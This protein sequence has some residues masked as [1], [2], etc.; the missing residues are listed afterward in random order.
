MGDFTHKE[1]C[2]YGAPN[3]PFY[4]HFKV[5]A[6]IQHEE[7]NKDKNNILHNDIALLRLDTPIQFDNKTW[8]VCLPNVDPRGPYNNSILTVVGWGRTLVE[9]DQIAKRAVGIRILTDHTVCEYAHESRLCA[10]VLSSQPNATRT[11]C[12]GDSGGPLMQQL[13][14]RIM[15]IEGIVSFQQGATCPSNFF[16]THYTRVRYH[17]KWIEENMRMD[18]DSPTSTSI[19]ER[20]FPTD[21]GHISI[22]NGETDQQHEYSWLATLMYKNEGYQFCVGS[23]INSRYVLTAASCVEKG[24]INK[25]GD[26]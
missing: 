25:S 16:P 14:K 23:V 17:M 21:C 22:L 13:D 18:D 7:Y 10:A 3:C 6:I 11:T 1:Y 9:N 24:W 15:V 20:K 26:L 4:Q 19:A 2:D 8:P 5:S 12:D